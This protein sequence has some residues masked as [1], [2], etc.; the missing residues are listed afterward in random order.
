MKK[1]LFSVCMV[2]TIIFSFPKPA[3]ADLFG[4]DV[5]VLVEILSESVQQLIQRKRSIKPIVQVLI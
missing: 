2:F 3:K 4:A 5:A 1:K